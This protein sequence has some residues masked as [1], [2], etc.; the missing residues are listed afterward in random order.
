MRRVFDAL[1]IERLGIA[2]KGSVF[3]KRRDA[4]GGEG[5]RGTMDSLSRRVPLLLHLLLLQVL[6]WTKI[7]GVTH[8]KLQ[9]NSIVPASAAPP[10][11]DG[12]AE[13]LFWSS[14]SG[15]DPEFSVLVKRTTGSPGGLGAIAGGAVGQG[16]R[17]CGQKSCPPRRLTLSKAG[18][19]SSKSGEAENS[20][21]R[22]SQEKTSAKASAPRNPNG[23]GPM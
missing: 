7:V 18:D 13:D 4:G 15:E 3:G 20:Q 1:Q 22:C 10:P 9:E 12:E 14:I 11:S 23:S 19:C 16:V 17:N 6:V 8:W 21:G 2:V 5:L